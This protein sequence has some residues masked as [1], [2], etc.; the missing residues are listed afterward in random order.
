MS[1]TMSEVRE[2]W[3]TPP[4]QCQIARFVAD[5]EWFDEETQVRRWMLD[6][7]HL[8]LM[9]RLHPSFIRFRSVIRTDVELM[10]DGNGKSIRYADTLGPQIVYVVVPVSEAEA[11]R[12]MMRLHLTIAATPNNLP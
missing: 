3:E 11:A 6:M 2:R 10:D 4:G 7:A 1:M 5:D 8:L 12:S 9:A